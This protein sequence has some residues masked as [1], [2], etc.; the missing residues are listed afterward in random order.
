MGT[1]P[2]TLTPSLPGAAKYTVPAI[3]H[4][5]SDS[6]VMDS[7][8]IAQFIEAEHPDPPLAYHSDLARIEQKAR[9]AAHVQIASVMPREIVMLSPR[10]QEYSPRSQQYF[11]STREASLG[12]RREDLLDGE[13]GVWTAMR[14]QLQE[15]SDLLEAGDGPFILGQHPS[16][17]DFFFAGVLQCAWVVHE[18]VFERYMQ[19]SGFARVYNACTPLLERDA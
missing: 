1:A 10:S 11:R 13:E 2:G 18:P 3:H 19:Y 12:H 6:I 7:V 16:N 9:A 17:T 8:P 5:P 4:L 15:L 14:P